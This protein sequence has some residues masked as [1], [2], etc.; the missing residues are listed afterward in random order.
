[1]ANQTRASANDINTAVERIIAIMLK[2]EI[3]NHAQFGNVRTGA[4]F[5]TKRI[6]AR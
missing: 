2:S 5:S 3:T 4:W 6:A 1:M